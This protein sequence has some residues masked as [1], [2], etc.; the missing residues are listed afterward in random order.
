MVI[1]AS[2]C[3]VQ[4]RRI[5]G[6][7]QFQGLALEGGNATADL[8]TVC[9]NSSTTLT[10]SN[11]QG[12]IEQWEIST[13]GGNTFA[14]I[15][16]TADDTA[17]FSD[18]ITNNTT[19]FRARVGANA[20]NF[21]FSDTVCINING[22]TTELYAEILEDLGQ[23]ATE[24]RNLYSQTL[25]KCRNT[26][27]TI[28]R[29]FDTPAGWS[30]D[31]AN[32]N[33]LKWESTT[34]C[35]DPSTYTEMP[36]TLGQLQAFAN[37]LPAQTSCYRAVYETAGCDSAYS[38]VARLVINTSPS[39]GAVVPPQLDIC[40]GERADLQVNSFSGDIIRWETADDA[41]FTTNVNNL[42]VT[43]ENISING[44]AQGT[45]FARAV[46]GSAGCD[47]VFSASSEITVAQAPAAG[48]LSGAQTICNGDPAGQLDYDNTGQV[49]T[50]NDWFSSTDNFATANPLGNGGNLTL[51][52]SPA[53][54]QTTCY[55]V[56]VQQGTCA[57]DSSNTVCI[58]VDNCNPGPNGDLSPDGTF[59]ETDNS[60]QTLT[61]AG[62]AGAITRWEYSTDNFTT[63]I[64]I[65]NTNATW[66]YSPDTL[67]DGTCFRVV[68]DDGGQTFSDTACIAI[69]QAITPGTIGSAQNRCPGETAQDLNLAG[70][71]QAPAFWQSSADCP[72]FTAP[73]DI[74]NTGATLS[75]GALAQTTCYRAVFTSNNSCPYD[76]TAP[77]T[78]TVNSAPNAGA[79]SGAGTV[80]DT[81]APGDLT[82]SGQTGN[83][84]RW[85]SSNDNFNANIVDEGNGGNA[86]FSFGGPLGEDRCYRVIVSNANCSDTTAEAC[87]DEAN[88]QTPTI[89]PDTDTVC[90]NDPTVRNLTVTVPGGLSVNDWESSTDGATFTSLGNNALTQTYSGLVN[91]NPPAPFT[92]FYRVRLDDGSGGFVFSDTA[93]VVVLVEPSFNNVSADQTVCSGDVPAQLSIT[94]LG[95]ADS[96]ATWQTSADCGGF[97]NPVNIPGTE[98][99]TNFT[100]GAV[101]SDTCFRALISNGFC[102]DA[103]S[104]VISIS[105]AQ[106]S[107]AGTV[108]GAQ[109]LCETDA[110]QDLQLDP[111]GQNGTVVEWRSSTDNF[112]SDAL[113]PGSAGQTTITP[114]NTVG[115]TCY[116]AVVQDA[117]C[118]ADSSNIVCV[119]ISGEPTVASASGGG[120][121]LPGRRR[122]GHFC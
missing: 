38:K 72:A 52:P 12:N 44:L 106:P 114:V 80:C 37:P 34:D 45:H 7:D 11:F 59:C 81:D 107:A 69:E 77:V 6:V 73:T 122:A 89:T 31:T 113:V 110:P 111:A 62:F 85:E 46:V 35:D 100:P 43:T 68:I 75:P 86:T 79:I 16:N 58:T 60:T 25:P 121:H 105:A 2:T 28:L 98:N 54:S 20:C 33:I 42:S 109:T 30:L 93:E 87:I 102:A 96:I 104:D 63:S 41:G 10:L 78:I 112:A 108:S 82:L 119:I 15:P 9:L 55:R 26:A 22:A 4:A 27:G 48:T 67:A 120:G 39:G 50:I 88:C 49:G 97:A 84:D 29:V 18:P 115:E 57:P 36:G 13:D 71:S 3:L 1:N 23:A 64:P 17:Y 40:A 83:I 51:T 47:T 76:T 116:R 117:P 66:D 95:A 8:P 94:G 92:F 70:N 90:T 99:Q 91:A 74:P 24:D 103:P 14:P 53:P 32:I 101:T 21:T 56:V 65:A 19:C 118:A 61:V 5:G